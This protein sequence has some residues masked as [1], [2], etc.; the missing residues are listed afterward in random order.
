MNNQ[1]SIFDKAKGLEVIIVVNYP[2]TQRDYERY[3]IETFKKHGIDIQVWDITHIYNINVSFEETIVDRVGVVSIETISELKQNIPLLTDKVWIYITFPI[4]IK[5]FKIYHLFSKQKGY[6]F[7]VVN[8]LVPSVK[9]TQTFIERLLRITVKKL[10][11]YL[12][13]RFVFIFFKAKFLFFHIDPVKILFGGGQ[14]SINAYKNSYPIGETTLMYNIHSFD[15]DIFL[16]GLNSGFNNDLVGSDYIV[17]LDQYLPYHPDSIFLNRKNSMDPD[18]Y[19]KKLNSFFDALESK[20]NMSVVIAVHPR[21]FYEDKGDPYKGRRMVQG[22]TNLLIKNASF[23]IA[24]TSTV[25]S[26]VILYKKPVVFVNSDDYSE[27]FNNAIISFTKALN[28][29]PVNLDHEPFD[30]DLSVDDALYQNY[31]KDYIK[32]GNDERLFWEQVI[33][34]LKLMSS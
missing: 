29:L 14:L 24:Q 4:D 22:Q 30:I 6:I 27:E 21:A 18:I 33:E 34:Q 20:Y 23:V 19:Y 11:K 16:R 15:Y 26:L 13:N 12:W 10:I 17:F 32:A 8:N 31:K 3:G 2:F 25:I 1:Q 7:S 5:S 9:R 28:K